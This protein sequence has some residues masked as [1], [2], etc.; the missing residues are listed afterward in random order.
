MADQG[1]KLSFFNRI[2]SNLVAL[3]AI[4]LL[5]LGLTHGMW[6][7]FL[8][9]SSPRSWDG[10][11]H[12]AIAQIYVSTIFPDTFGWTYA[13]FGG[14]PLPNFYPPLFYWLIGLVHGTRLL[15]FNSAF[16][17]VLAVPVILTPAAI[18]L[19]ALAASGR[20]RTVATCAAI[21]AV[22]MLIDPRFIAQVG[23]SGLDY[24]STFVLGLYSQPLGFVLLALWYTSFLK[25]PASRACF[26]L[27]TILLALTVLANFFNAVTASIFVVT[28]LFGDVV[29]LLTAR[30]DR[31]RSSVVQGLRAHLVSPLLSACLCAFWLVPVLDEYEYFVTRPVKVISFAMTIPFAVWLWFVAAEL[32][33]I[34]WF[35]SRNREMGAFLA[36][37]LLL[38]A[39]VIFDVLFAPSWFPLQAT[40]F[41]AT[42]NFLLCVP[43]GY[44]LATIYH[45]AVS[46]FAGWLSKGFSGLNK[47][48]VWLPKIIPLLTFSVAVTV[49]WA[50]LHKSVRDSLS[51]DIA[52]YSAAN[53][54][55]VTDLLAFAKE[56]RRG[57]YLVESPTLITSA[58]ADLDGRQMASGLGT[59]GNESLIV[60]FR[61]ASPN[62]LFYNP[63]VS[64]FSAFP[65]GFGIS[66]TLADDL[67]FMNQPTLLHL[68]RLSRLGVKYLV[69]YTETIKQRL[70]LEQLIAVRYDIGKWSVFELK[71]QPA[72]AAQA[73]AYRPALVISKF[74]LKQRRRNEY[75]FIRFAE[76]QFSDG[77]FE[78]LL[79][80]SPEVR[81]DHLGPV[82]DFGGIVVDTYECDNE[83][84][85][86]G[87][88]RDIAQ[89]RLVVLLSS[90][91]PLFRRIASDIAAFPR[92]RIVERFSEPPG[93]WMDSETP[94]FRYSTSSI[95][96]VW[97]RIKEILN[98]EKLRVAD[99]APLAVSREQNAITLTPLASL[100]QRVPVLLD[101]TFHPDWRRDD[102]AAIYAV[103]P[104][105]MLT[106]LERRVSL[107]YERSPLER[108]AAELSAVTLILLV[109]GPVLWSVRNR[110]L[111][112]WP[113]NR[114]PVDKSNRTVE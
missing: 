45:Q 98:A 47:R 58:G 32:G 62:S 42:L 104:F 82:D 97:L 37:C 72:A 78:V 76:E 4:T 90:D 53:R 56:H 91:A 77:W 8:R 79:A 106:F 105:N 7:G 34:L 40:R 12:Y 89:R 111:P 3:T 24:F 19:F 110:L 41:L 51:V 70:S 16:K 92:A 69:I 46:L 112:Y 28:I 36:T 113:T 22:P 88:I 6:L 86:F 2:L 68:E 107:T 38:A 30:D 81:L 60:V 21:A 17:L 52:F 13:Y 67:D 87:K 18:W 100:N 61:E 101:T 103:T 66:S 25:A 23:P 93:Q 26:M 33:I 96:K 9:A 54:R 84:A 85:A 27:S 39:I 114:S 63:T 108:G 99:D 59:Q 31:Q 75:N 35:R 50:I 65:E 20:N 48:S 29:A 43:I 44:A 74:T 94:T 73:L 80:R 71:Q 5:P 95:H 102:H 14:M 15:S 49:L 10:T 1:K 57:R 64:A 109:V 83:D 55:Q 11:G